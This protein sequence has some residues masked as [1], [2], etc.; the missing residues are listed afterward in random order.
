MWEEVDLNEW[1]KWRSRTLL[2]FYF[3]TFYIG[4]LYSGYLSTE[5]LYIKEIVDGKHAVT[6]YS[7]G[8]GI[9]CFIALLSVIV[10]SIYYDFT[11]DVKRLSVIVGFLVLIGNVLYVLPYSVW[12]VVTGIALI[13]T[14]IASIA[15]LIAEL[16]H[17]VE[18]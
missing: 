2:F 7:V 16:T 17:I 1:K 4:L 9:S 10:G 18:E 8:L 15:A 11:L 5:L 12:L 6:Y 3:V 14:A 13:Y